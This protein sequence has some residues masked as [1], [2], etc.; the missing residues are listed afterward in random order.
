MSSA[1]V[2]A[3]LFMSIRERVKRAFYYIL[4]DV[5]HNYLIIY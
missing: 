4:I 3:A 5:W 2:G 1:L